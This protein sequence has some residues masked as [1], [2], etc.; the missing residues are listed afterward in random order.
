MRVP[1]GWGRRAGKDKRMSYYPPPRTPPASTRRLA[2]RGLNARAYRMGAA[3]G[4][5]PHL[6]H[7]GRVGSCSMGAPLSLPSPSTQG[8][9][10]Y[11]EGID[12][13]TTNAALPSGRW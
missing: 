4:L 12:A 3:C 2:G 13:A 11:S 5:L 6:A 7:K 9:A 1:A 10:C 8:M